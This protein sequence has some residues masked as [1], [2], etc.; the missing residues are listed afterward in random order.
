MSSLRI[1]EKLAKMAT[2]IRNWYPK[3]SRA[4]LPIYQ[5]IKLI[6]SR[7]NKKSKKKLA[8]IKSSKIFETN[9]F[10]GNHSYS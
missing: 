5:Y 9:A 7:E 4:Y 6:F 8:K 1:S 2:K 10:E 3:S